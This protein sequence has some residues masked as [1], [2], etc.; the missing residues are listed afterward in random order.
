[1]LHPGTK[2]V[3]SLVLVSIVH[4]KRMSEQNVNKKKEK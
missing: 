4:A 1:M 2:W 3:I